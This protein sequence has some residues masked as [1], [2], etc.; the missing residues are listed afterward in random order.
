MS[1]AD[2]LTNDFLRNAGALRRHPEFATEL[3]ELN[4]ASAHTAR[5]LKAGKLTVRQASELEAHFVEK[6]IEVIPPGDFHEMM[7]DGRLTEL[8]ALAGYDDD[9]DAADVADDRKALMNKIKADALEEAWLSQKI[10]S[11]RYAEESRKLSGSNED[12]DNRL[13]D[14]DGPGVAVEYFAGDD[15]PTHDADL[16]RFMSKTYGEDYKGREE[17]QRSERTPGKVVRETK[18]PDER[19]DLQKMLQSKLDEIAVQEPRSAVDANG[20]TDLDLL[21]EQG[22]DDF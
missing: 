21:A 11:T 10:D 5:M 17:P 15:Q 12:L 22:I 18:T 4:H 7:K 6:L 9:R 13:A 1:I 2:L 20:I 3:T 16:Q 14:G 8:Q 19:T